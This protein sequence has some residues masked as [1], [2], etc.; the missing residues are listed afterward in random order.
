ML[1]NGI[2]RVDRFLVFGANGIFV[3]PVETHGE[4][5][6]FVHGGDDQPHVGRQWVSHVDRQ[7]ASDF[8]KLKGGDDNAL[9]SAQGMAV[10]CSQYLVS[11]L[12]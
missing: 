8:G 6:V 4:L 2:D 7:W 1:E 10:A 9:I 5:A 11:S 3:T 12:V